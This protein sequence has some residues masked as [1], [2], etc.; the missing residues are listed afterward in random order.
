MP[1]PKD[2][3]QDMNVPPQANA[4]AAAVADT[5]IDARIGYE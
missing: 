2:A 5:P 4:A 3:P 1:V